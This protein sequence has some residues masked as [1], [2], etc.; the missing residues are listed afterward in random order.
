MKGRLFSCPAPS[1]YSTFRYSYKLLKHAFI[2]LGILSHE[3][4]RLVG[5]A[6]GS[7]PMLPNS[8]CSHALMHANFCTWYAGQFNKE[9]TVEWRECNRNHALC[10][11][12]MCL[13]DWS[14]D[15]ITSARTMVVLASTKSPSFKKKKTYCRV[16]LLYFSLLSLFDTLY[17]ISHFSIFLYANI[18]M[19]EMFKNKNACK[20]ENHEAREMLLKKKWRGPHHQMF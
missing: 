4:L 16:N 14:L 18:S 2:Y 6:I 9:V 3:F 10:H 7:L 8:N 1:L 13:I 19:I 17:G 11:P 20:T 5:E 15:L 12:M